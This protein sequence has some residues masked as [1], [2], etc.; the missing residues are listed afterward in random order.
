MLDRIIGFHDLPIQSLI[1]RHSRWLGAWWKGLSLLSIC[2]LQGTQLKYNDQKRHNLYLDFESVCSIRCY[3][4]KNHSR[5][6]FCLWNPELVLIIHNMGVP[7][8][9]FQ[10][11]LKYKTVPGIGR[12]WANACIMQSYPFCCVS[13]EIETS[14]A[15]DFPPGRLE[16]SVPV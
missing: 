16:L 10:V 4:P 8:S 11:F 9:G 1:K 13:V 12:Y 6:H 14:R 2:R 7:I 3:H 5:L 15:I